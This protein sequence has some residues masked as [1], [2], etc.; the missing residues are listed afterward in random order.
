VTIGITGGSGTLGRLLSARLAGGSVPC[1]CFPGDVRSAAELQ[2]WVERARPDRVVHLAARVPLEQVAADPLTA[3]DVNVSGTAN[4]LRAL[5]GLPEVPW[6]FYA[7]TSHVY[8]STDSPIG[9]D[10]EVRPQ[11]VYAETKWLA[12]QVVE[13]HV[14][15]GH[16]RACIG[17]IFS[18]YHPSQAP[19]FLYPSIVERLARHDP[20]APFPL[21]GGNSV[22]DLSNAEQVV[23]AILRLAER[24]SEGIVNIGSGVGTT[25]ADFVRSLAGGELAIEVAQDEPVT[26]LVA[27]V[28]RLRSLTGHG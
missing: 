11:N 10:G 7:S 20:R 8:R 27:D 28:A 22:R 15:R 2:E 9:E 14:R 1:S 5:A 21:R 18:F 24:E 23:D 13:F 19:P 16:V 12:E 6:L 25:I 4:L 17:R 3:F 26:A